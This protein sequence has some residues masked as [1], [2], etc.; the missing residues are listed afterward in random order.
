[1]NEIYNIMDVFLLLTTG[2]G[3][4]IPII[5]AM[6]CEIPVLTTNYT[7]GPEIVEENMAGELVNVSDEILGGWHVDRAIPDIKD[8]AEKIIKFYNNPELRKEYGK[9]GRAAVLN[10]Y[11]W[12]KISK[13]W[14]RVLRGLI[15]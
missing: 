14:D 4:G 1:M 12:D 2:E 5:E 15:G 8:A 6:A 11:S 3:F 13:K 10:Y 7:T 9:N